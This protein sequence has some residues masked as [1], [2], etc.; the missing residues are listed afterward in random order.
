MLQS[1][2]HD[3]EPFLAE[4]F[5]FQGKNYSGVFSAV[6]EKSVMEL[7]GFAD[8]ADMICVS[9]RDQWTQLPKTEEQITRGRFGTFAIRGLKIDWSS[10]MMALKK[11]ST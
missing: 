7:G 1:A 10:V 5:T 11:V 8:E 9:S 3:A 2:F 4:P 6:D